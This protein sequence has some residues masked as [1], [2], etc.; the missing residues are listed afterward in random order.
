[1]ATL[2]VEP[3]DRIHVR[4]VHEDDHLIVVDKP[5]GLVTQP[6]VGHLHDT[7]LNGLFAHHGTRL[8]NLGKARD[9]G[10]VHRLDA[11]ASGLLVVALTAEAY[12]GLRARFASREVT[13]MY[14]AVA[15]KAPRDATGVIKR[16][17]LEEVRPKTKYTSEKIGRLSTDGKP[18]ITAY[19]VLDKSDLGA[20]L[21]ARPITGRLHQVRIHLA[22]IGCGL[23]GDKLYGP[24]LTDHA[25]P[26]VALHAHRLKFEHPVTGEAAEYRSAF[27]K[28]LRPLLRRLNLSRPDL[29]KP[30][31]DQP[32]NAET[33]E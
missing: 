21:E 26:R 13:K 6:G 12:D 25:A 31:D 1:M 4:I 10:L 32:D 20:L 2:S 15:H 22:S 28:D 18:A 19:R 30:A 33:A 17:I 3:N 27:P 29:G 16:A 7:L 5:P 24:R 11:D 23:L 9:F 8:Q 14:W